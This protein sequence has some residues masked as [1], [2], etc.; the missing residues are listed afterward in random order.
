MINNKDSVQ[1]GV[2]LKIRD[3]RCKSWMRA[4]AFMII[5]CF[6]YQDLTSKA[7]PDYATTLNLMFQRPAPIPTNPI[8]AFFCE[9]AYAEDTGDDSYYTPPAA[10]YSFDDYAP[11]PEIFTPAYQPSAVTYTPSPVEFHLVDPSVYDFSDTSAYI[12][13]YDVSATTSVYDS[14][15]SYTSDPAT[16][17]SDPSTQFNLGADYYLANIA[18]TSSYISGHDASATS[19]IIPST[20]SWEKITYDVHENPE[21]SYGLNTAILPAYKQSLADGTINYYAANGNLS[22]SENHFS[23]GTKITNI[24]G[25]KTYIDPSGSVGNFKLTTM[26]KFNNAVGIGFTDTNRAKQYQAWVGRELTWA[27]RPIGS[28]AY[29]QSLVASWEGRNFGTTVTGV[30]TNDWWHKEPSL[31]KTNLFYNE[32]KPKMV[33]EAQKLSSEK[34][35]FVGDAY[36]QVVDQ[37]KPK[38]EELGLRSVSLDLYNPITGIREFA[39]KEYAVE[40]GFDPGNTNAIVNLEGEGKIRT[41]SGD[42]S[43]RLM[44]IGEGNT[45]V[46]TYIQPTPEGY[47]YAAKG[48]VKSWVPVKTLGIDT[49]VR[50]MDIGVETAEI[51]SF[52]VRL[53]QEAQSLDA[54][55]FALHAKGR[56]FELLNEEGGS[57]LSLYSKTKVIANHVFNNGIKIPNIALLEGDVEYTLANKQLGSLNQS[58]GAEWQFGESI[59]KT[60]EE[61]EN[62][63]N[64]LMLHEGLFVGGYGIKFVASTEHNP[65]GFVSLGDPNREIFNGK[66]ASV[67]IPEIGQETYVSFASNKFLTG[68]LIV[69]KQTVTAQDITGGKYG[70]SIAFGALTKDSHYAGYTD[71]EGKQAFTIAG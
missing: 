30:V 35:I 47:S 71:A 49:G 4:V 34:E 25:Q 44:H 58:P 51:N 9:N 48:E 59:G 19:P 45:P 39:G 16:Y 12:S 52:D 32:I 36:R 7:G 21:L 13:G 5:F 33:A 50:L 63:Q 64:H 62:K 40:K 54:Q 65:S 28:S 42:A 29:G 23:D 60:P 55:K 38:L 1:S 17:T 10:A 41:S 46:K 20:S 24:G 37:W 2:I 66:F 68:S 26:E 67:L 15:S 27:E 61:L 3:P 14:S 69:P 6:V 31:E 57:K 43:V 22:H 8:M 53:P 18:N 70:D 11:V 56:A